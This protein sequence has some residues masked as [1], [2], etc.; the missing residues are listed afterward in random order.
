M[1]QAIERRL[2]AV[3]GTGV[4]RRRHGVVR[5]ALV[6]VLAVLSMAGA[7]RAA[8]AQSVTLTS[9]IDLV[10]DADL[11]HYSQT[12]WRWA[13][14]TVRG[15]SSITLGQCGCLLSAFAT[16]INQQGR[17]LPWFPTPFNYFGGYDGAFDFN[18][19][20]IDIFLNHGP[21]PTAPPGGPGSSFPPGWGYKTRP[22]GTCGGKR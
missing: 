1:Y 11:V 6:S 19:R 20:Y 10:Q 3:G 16:I 8:R 7:A 5:R 12:D 9:D 18:P 17:M 21:N 13:Y 15:D 14:F 22:P 2:A 4:V